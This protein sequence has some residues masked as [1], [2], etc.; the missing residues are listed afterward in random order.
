M[1]RKLDDARV[2]PAGERGGHPVYR[3]RDAIEAWGLTRTDP[4]TMDPVQRRAH[5][6]AELEQIELQTKKRELIPRIEVE[7]EEARRAKII[8][9]V[10]DTLPDVLERD[11]GLAPVVVSRIEQCID[12]VRAELADR[13]ADVS[14]V[15][16]SEPVEA[17]Q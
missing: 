4:S 14:D 8:T 10:L 2:A 1:R 6:Q 15:E 5:Y 16:A 17:E 9:Q 3:L 13:I 11:C 12:A 7:Q